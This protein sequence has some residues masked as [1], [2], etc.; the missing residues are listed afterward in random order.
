MLGSCRDCADFL[1]N[2]EILL[3]LCKTLAELMM[4]Y[5]SAFNVHLLGLFGVQALSFI[6]AVGTVLV[7]NQ[8]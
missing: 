6:H 4:S 3:R 2:V 1:L 5:H 7:F 8:Y